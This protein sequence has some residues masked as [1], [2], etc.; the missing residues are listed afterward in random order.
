[1]T[2]VIPMSRSKQST[3]EH[4]ESI[5]NSGSDN[6][7]D[8]VEGYLE[9]QKMMKQMHDAMLKKRTTEALELCVQIAATARLTAYKIKLDDSENPALHLGR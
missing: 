8:W 2:P 1:M 6:M 7:I 3:A 9:M 4:S 5:T